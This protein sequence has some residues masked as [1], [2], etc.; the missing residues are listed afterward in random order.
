[1]TESNINA[2]CCICGVGYHVCNDCLSQ[3]T[4]KP[5]R[6]VVDNIEHYKIY[7]ALHD[8]SVTKNKEEA[9]AELQKCDL[10][11]I[12]S[13]IPEI[14]DVINEIMGDTTKT[15]NSSKKAVAAETYSVNLKNDVE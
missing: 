12:D 1:M 8:Y 7:Y 9:K 6:S 15:K 4:L 2:Y 13:F 10:T 5:W 3:K 11:D 14:R